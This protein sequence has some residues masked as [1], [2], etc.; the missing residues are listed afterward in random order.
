VEDN[1]TF[2][3]QNIGQFQFDGSELLQKEIV[4]FTSQLFRIV[5]KCV[6]KNG[7]VMVSSSL[8]ME[9]LQA[10]FEKD[11]SKAVDYALNVLGDIEIGFENLKHI[12]S[13]SLIHKSKTVFGISGDEDNAFPI[14]NSEGANDLMRHLFK[15]KDA[16]VKVVATDAVLEDIKEKYSTR[17]IGFVMSQGFE[18]KYELFEVLDAC[19][20][21]EKSKKISTKKA[22][23]AGLKLFY[24]NNF[25]QARA[26]FSRVLQAN[27]EDRIAK[28]YLLI[29]DKCYKDSNIKTSHEL[30]GENI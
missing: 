29:C 11:S 7:G 1:Y 12:D 27:P 18:K 22:F 16:G 9:L 25:Y 10:I 6:N 20:T 30:L 19:E 26:E 4:D 23:E 24:D 17:Y 21:T 2:V 5:N 3:M 28:W 15:L 8:G 14:V 13:I